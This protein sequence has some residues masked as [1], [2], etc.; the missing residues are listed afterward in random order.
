MV[1]LNFQTSDLPMQ[2]NQGKFEYNGGCGYLLKPD[3]MRRPDKTFDPFAESPVDGVIAAQCSVRVIS[4]Q[5]L[6]DKKV[7]TYVEVDMYGLPTDTIRKEF[8]TR[9]VPSNGLNPVYNEEPFTFRKV[10]FLFTTFKA[11]V[12]PRKVL[13]YNVVCLFALAIQWKE[14][15]NKRTKLSISGKFKPFK[16]LSLV[17]STNDVIQ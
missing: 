3:F 4:G 14:R 16:G 10:S 2:L 1:A 8:R 9:M 5:F 13:L 15:S 17:V 7:G 6:S 12:P 11:S